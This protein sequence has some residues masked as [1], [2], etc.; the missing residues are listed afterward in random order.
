MSESEL[1]IWTMIALLGHSRHRHRWDSMPDEIRLR[2]QQGEDPDAGRAAPLVLA[3][4]MGHLEIIKVLLEHGADVH[5]GQRYRTPL[6]LAS[7]NPDIYSC[8]LEHGARETF[9]T[10][11][12]CGNIRGI[13]QE[14]RRD[15]AL[16]NLKDE[17]DQT[18]LFYAIG[19]SNT[20]VTRL[21][22]AAGADPNWVADASYG[23]SPIHQAG[24]GRKNH[25]ATF[26]DLLVERSANL[27]AQD[28]G[29]VTALHM[30]VRD[31]DLAAVTRLL[32]HGADPNIEDRGR[33]STPLRRA[34]ANTGRSG[35]G[36]TQD[37]AIEITKLLLAHGADPR[38]LNSS[39]KRLVD[40]TRNRV[41][42]DLLENADSGADT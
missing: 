2:L 21:L 9:F 12:A 10:T 7:A 20:E 4:E 16:S 13:E 18:P 3:A 36:G 15:P 29:G 30:A 14:L 22:L 6:L 32:E 8:L 31:R 5:G 37:V 24:R 19:Y 25:S 33:K 40:S 42:R 39:G 34:V 38:H 28:K 27:D 23:I 35:T 26:I 1:D 41:I 17:S 11:V